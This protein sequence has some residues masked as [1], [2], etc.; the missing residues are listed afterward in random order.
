[1][2]EQPNKVLLVDDDP[3]MRRLISKWLELAGYQVKTAENG[4]EAIAIIEKERP[5]ILLTDWEMPVMDGLALCR[6]VRDQQRINYIYTILFTIRTSTPDI[7]RGLE[8]GADDFCKK[9]LDRDELMARL[10]SGSRVI[11]L[12]QRLLELGLKD[13]L[14]GLLTRGALLELMEKE[15]ARSQRSSSGMSCVLLDI[16]QLKQINDKF[17][18]AVGDEALRRVSHILVGNARAGD[19]IGRFGSEEFCAVLPESREG[20]AAQW[21]ERMR[22]LIKAIRIP[23]EGGSELCVSASFGTA[24]R[25]EDTN[26]VEQLVDMAE[27]AMLVS[28]R[29]GRDRVTAFGSLSSHRPAGKHRTPAELL[30]HVPARTVMSLVA[31]LHRYDTLGSACEYFLRFRIGSAPVVD[32]EGKL[33][34]ILSEKDVMT[35]MLRQDWWH[36]TVGNVMQRNVVFYEEETTAMLV[37][38]FLCRVTIRSVVIVK[39]GKP[40]GLIN[41]GSLLRF[42]S[43]LLAVKQGTGVEAEAAAANQAIAALTGKI[44]PRQ[45]ISHLVRSVTAEAADLARRVHG[46]TTDLVPCVVGGASRLQDLVTD[47]LVFSRFADEPYEGEMLA[48][49]DLDQQPNA[50]AELVAA[51][52]FR[53]ARMQE[54]ERAPAPL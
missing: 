25:R 53:E 37:Y 44:S 27:Q 9:P 21:A 11:G 30:Q 6:W 17:G 49:I 38:E 50:H 2:Y 8:A 4:R 36:L 40:T 7:V 42:F 35:T 45:R 3:A 43:N 13:P 39:D 5:Q 20:G 41:R 33:V 47:L 12:E 16:D 15:L 48:D 19:M 14:T 51:T 24:E 23:I 22:N 29:S 34:G 46:K 1:M 52:N 26:T 10:R 18:H 31:S 32:A 28:K 54:T